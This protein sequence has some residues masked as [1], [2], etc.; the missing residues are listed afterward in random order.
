M[1]QTYPARP[2]ID[3]APVRHA[4][5]SRC[6]GACHADF[7]CRVRASA[8]LR[9]ARQILHSVHQQGRRPGANRYVGQRGMQ[10][11]SQP[12]S[13]EEVFY[14]RRGVEYI[15]DRLLYAVG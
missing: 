9:P 8:E 5:Y 13:M 4:G 2:T 3:I 15:C 14:S 12:C 6:N 10:R 11:M 7:N 1:C